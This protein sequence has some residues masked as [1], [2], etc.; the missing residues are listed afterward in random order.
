VEVLQLARKLGAFTVVGN[1]EVASLRAHNVRAGGA[2]PNSEPKYRWTDNMSAADLDLIR[3][4][5]F[6]ISIPQ[7]NAIVVHA[8]LVPGIELDRQDPLNMVTM[9]NLLKKETKDACAVYDALETDA[10][11][12]AAWASVWSGP[13]HVYFGHDAKRRL[14]RHPFATGLDTGC[15]YGDRLTAAILEPG[16]PTT[17]VHVPARAQYSAPPAAPAA[18]QSPTPLRG[19]AAACWR[20]VGTGGGWAAMVVLAAAA[21]MGTRGVRRCMSAAQ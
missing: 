11:G 21:W 20:L 4:M 17:L 6:T 1:H 13:A 10:E 5:P 2:H 18:A 14:Q 16:A 8:G 7:H 15:V 12:T 19:L 3:K 9:R